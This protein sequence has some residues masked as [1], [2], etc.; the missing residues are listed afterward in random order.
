LARHRTLILGK[1]ALKKE[2]LIMFRLFKYLPVII[3]IIQKGRKDPRV[4][5]TIANVKA[6]L[7]KKTDPTSPKR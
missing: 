2:T 4:Q 7:H 3:P 5:K 1:S 6:R